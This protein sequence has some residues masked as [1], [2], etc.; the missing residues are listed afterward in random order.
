LEELCPP[1][2]RDQW[3][4]RSLEE[5]L[6]ELEE[7]AERLDVGVSFSDI[8]EPL[9]QECYD[10][11][12]H[13]QA[14]EQELVT[15]NEALAEATNGRVIAP[16]VWMEWDLPCV[17]NTTWTSRPPW[18]GLDVGIGVCTGYDENGRT[19]GRTNHYAYWESRWC[20]LHCGCS[21]ERPCASI[22]YRVQIFPM[23]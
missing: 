22:R 18:E 20:Y 3:S 1:G 7:A 2:W 21:S 6:L 16:P 19:L 10:Y 15:A 23:D 5:E 14:L 4:P 12:S 13:Y 9:P 17:D 11:Q 8:E